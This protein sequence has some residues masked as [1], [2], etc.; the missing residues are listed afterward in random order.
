MFSFA[1]ATPVAAPPAAVGAPPA[2]NVTLVRH[3]Q[4]RTL[5]LH[6]KK[7][8]VISNKKKASILPEAVL[9]AVHQCLVR[10]V[11]SGTGA[12]ASILQAQIIED[13]KGIGFGHYLVEEGG[14]FACSTS[15]IRKQ[16]KKLRYSH[17]AA[18]A[19]A[20][21]LPD[22]WEVSFNLIGKIIKVLFA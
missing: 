17:R 18:T 10:H 13:I 8:R 11:E 9:A 19:V 4:A 21:Q 7:R 3:G 6:R 2:Q 14:P 12:T 15:W 16:L 20:Q 1:A 5:T 22:N